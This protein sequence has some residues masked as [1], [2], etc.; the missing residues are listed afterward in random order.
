MPSFEDEKKSLDNKG[1]LI[2]GVLIFIVALVICYYVYK[3]IT[4]VE[5][6]S[7]GCPVKGPF[8]E[9]VVLFDQT[10]TVKDK[11]IVEVDARN[12]LD[13]IKID[14]PQYSRL[15]I[16]V[17]K[18]DPE[19][20]NIKPVISVCNPGDER[21]LS[22]FEKSGITLTVKKYM[23]DWEKNFSQI[24]NPVINKIMERSTSPTS[25]IF[26]MINVVSINSFKHSNPKYIHKL[27]I[28]SDFMHHTSEYSFYNASDINIK[29]FTDTR[30]FK[31]VYS[32]LRDNVDVELYCYKRYENGQCD[33]VEG[34]WNKY[35]QEIDA[36]NNN[37]KFSRIGS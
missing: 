1:F 31:N 25:P 24:I 11:P 30:Y 15:S 28:F 27:V 32:S 17:I 9:H 22:Y 5:L 19:G 6:N 21:N 18:N 3:S 37:I 16:Y 10:D 26:E 29:K 23:E 13:K 35:F 4:S 2:F 33:N 20:R 36:H 14:V 34:F 12:F 7:K 8:S